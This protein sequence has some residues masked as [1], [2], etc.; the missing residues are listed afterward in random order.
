M[1]DYV[2]YGAD[3]PRDQETVRLLDDLL[4][5]GFRSDPV[6]LNGTYPA[7]APDRACD[8]IPVADR[9]YQDF[10]WQRDPFEMRCNG[11]NCSGDQVDCDGSRESAGI[12]YILPYW[13]ARYYGVIT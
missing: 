8:P 3:T 13:M 12:D 11:V 5:R 6:D 1:L 2:L 4:T 9:P 7:C 10:L